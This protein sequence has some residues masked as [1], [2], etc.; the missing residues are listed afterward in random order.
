MPDSSVLGRSHSGPCPAM[1]PRPGLA[2]RRLN[3]RQIRR[4]L[5]AAPRLRHD[6]LMS[7]VLD[8]SASVWG[9]NDVLGLRREVL[10]IAVEHLSGLG[11]MSRWHLQIGTFDYQSVFDLPVTKLDRRG[12][13]RAQEVLLSASP[14]SSSILGPSLRRAEANAARFAGPRLLIVLSDFELFDSNPM[15][16]LRAMIHS[17][18]TEVL[19]ISLNGEPPTVLVDSRVRTVRLLPT[20]TPADFANHIVDAAHAC[21]SST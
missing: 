10:L 17:S 21:V 8:E 4:S 9:G 20:D 1:R 2:A 3:A 6:T 12:L 11:L 15:A 19:A 5:R 16:S 7:V 14:G 13:R 18:A